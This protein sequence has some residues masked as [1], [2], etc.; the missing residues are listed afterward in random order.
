MGAAEG[1]RVQEGL[2][3]EGDHGGGEG[4]WGEGGR[5]RAAAEC[6]AS[7]FVA[8]VIDRG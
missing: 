7:S 4:G 2:L 8:M 5:K 6:F 1:L 3:V